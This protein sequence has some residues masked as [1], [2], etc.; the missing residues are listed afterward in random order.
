MMVMSIPNVLTVAGNDPSGGAGVAADLKTFAALG[1]YGMAVITALTAQ[2]TCG[3][4]AV[5]PVSAG[6]VE[7]QLAAVFDDVRVDAVKIGM[8]PDAEVVRVVASC[9]GRYATGP[10]ILDPVLYSSGGVPLMAAGALGVLR[11]ELLTHVDLITP[12]LTEAAELLGTL[13]ARTREGMIEQ[14]CRLRELGPRWVLVKGGHLGG[15]SSPDVLAGPEGVTWLTADRLNTRNDHGTGCTLSAA[16][17]ALAV[18]RGII[19]AASL[20]KR[21]LHQALEAADM[22]SV[23]QGRG[24]VNHSHG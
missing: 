15:T 21:Y 7:D 19:V 23:G 6:I 24:P 16:I 11:D 20:A 18:D 22:L 17:A 3:V 9:L 2:N 4:R 1:V 12:N 5:H 14:A 10:V 8:L 13:P